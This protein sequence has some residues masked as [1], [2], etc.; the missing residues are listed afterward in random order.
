MS[1]RWPASNTD[2]FA[3]KLKSGTFDNNIKV[4]ELKEIYPNLAGKYT[5]Q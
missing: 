2:Y 1:K 3:R 5:T 4:A